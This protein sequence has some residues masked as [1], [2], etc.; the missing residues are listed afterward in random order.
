MKY[1]E[2][3]LIQYCVNLYEF[4]VF[5]KQMMK[6]SELPGM[7]RL[8]FDGPKMQQNLIGIQYF[9]NYLREV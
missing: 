6:K 7:F 4:G 9:T 1:H 8:L 3:E 2:H 5:K